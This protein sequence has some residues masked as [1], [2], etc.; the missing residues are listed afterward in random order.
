MNKA[1]KT[2]TFAQRQ[3]NRTLIKPKKTH[4]NHSGI[5]NQYYLING[6]KCGVLV[7]VQMHQNQ[8]KKEKRRGK[9]KERDF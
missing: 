6:E 5:Q 7:F 2:K 3:K 9:K 1:T 8:V 4:S